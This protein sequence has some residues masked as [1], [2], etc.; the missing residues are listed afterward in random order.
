MTKGSLQ[1]RVNKILNRAEFIA[2]QAEELC[3]AVLAELQDDGVN[4]GVGVGD[5][6]IRFVRAAHETTRQIECWADG[7][8]WAD[9][10]REEA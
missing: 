1:K 2:T 8:L 6:A 4:V 10:L 3:A 5:A 9:E 7:A